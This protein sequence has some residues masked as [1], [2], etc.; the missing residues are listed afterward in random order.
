MK[1]LAKT[2]TGE[3]HPA[4]SNRRAISA[5]TCRFVIGEFSVIGGGVN[6]KQS[7]TGSQAKPSSLT[8][9]FEVNS[10]Q[11]GR[12]RSAGG[13]FKEGL[14]IAQPFF[15]VETTGAKQLNQLVTTVKGVLEGVGTTKEIVHV[16]LLPDGSESFRKRAAFFEAQLLQSPQSE[17]RG[18][19]LFVCYRAKNVMG[20]RL[21]GRWAPECPLEMGVFRIDA[22]LPQH[23]LDVGAVSDVPPSPPREDGCQI[24]LHLGA[25][26]KH[27]VKTAARRRGTRRVE[28][29]PEYSSTILSLPD[30][31]VGEIVAR[32][33]SERSSASVRRRMC[34]NSK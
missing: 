10:T 18:T 20:F 15:E 33:R 32:I 31:V 14:T 9:P 25:R 4:G 5:R 34:P 17:I 13:I 24:A 8:G 16:E 29:H 30:S 2:V 12:R 1:I 27:V 28:Y 7:A 11:S 23:H 21:I 26:P 19:G 22:D 3:I 6:R